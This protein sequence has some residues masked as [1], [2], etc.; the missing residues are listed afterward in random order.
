M[1]RRPQPRP[2]FDFQI[3]IDEVDTFLHRNETNARVLL[4][5]CRVESPSLIADNEM[6]PAVRLPQTD[7]TLADPTMLRR[8]VQRLLQDPK[9]AQ[10]DVRREL[11]RDVCLLYTSPSPRDS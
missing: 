7:T 3:A 8:V 11:T 10:R 9:Q 1:N 6:N 2:R 5:D 4:R